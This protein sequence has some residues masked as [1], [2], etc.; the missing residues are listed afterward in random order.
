MRPTSKRES[1][2]ILVADVNQ[3]TFLENVASNQALKSMAY[4]RGLC[5]EDVFD[6]Y[7][8]RKVHID[9]ELIATFWSCGGR[10]DNRYSPDRLQAKLH[11]DVRTQYSCLRTG[12]DHRGDGDRR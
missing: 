4:Q 5:R 2:L 8:G 10:R 3:H 9:V 11:H 12:V 7:V 1:K 6:D